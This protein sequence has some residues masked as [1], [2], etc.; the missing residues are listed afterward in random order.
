MEKDELKKLKSQALRSA[1][2]RIGASKSLIEFSD[3]EWEAVQA[4]AL[5]PTLLGKILKNSN[6]DQVKQLSMP[7]TQ[8]GLSTA[9]L[10]RAK[11]MANNGYSQSDIASALGVSTTTINTALKA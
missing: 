8:E 1:R 6:K 4:G 5:S 7:R 3:K 9:H 11:A 10:A 2:Q